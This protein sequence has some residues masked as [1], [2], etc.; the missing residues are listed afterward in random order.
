MGVHIDQCEGCRGIFLDR[1]ELEQIAGAEQRHYGGSAVPP[2]PAAYR[3][4]SPPPYGQPMH[5]QHG[6][7]DSPPPYGRAG[8]GGGHY[9]DSP[10]PHGYGHGGRRRRS[11]LEGLF[12]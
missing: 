8:Y 12:D 11:F 6:Y 2:P 4:D 9:G 7:G 5:R 10:P 1:G 3:A